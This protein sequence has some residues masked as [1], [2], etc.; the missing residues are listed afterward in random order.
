MLLA[1]GGMR[2]HLD[3]GFD[4]DATMDEGFVM[5]VKASSAP[6]QWQP[7]SMET[8]T[9]LGKRPLSGG[10]TAL[11]RENVRSW[12]DQPGMS[13]WANATSQSAPNTAFRSTFGEPSSYVSMGMDLD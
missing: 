2:G 11:D 4:T 3:D 6:E 7:L 5:D 8:G 13:S 10:F 1:G 9:R 12:R